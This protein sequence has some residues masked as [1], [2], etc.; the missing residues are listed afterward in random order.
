MSLTQ[1]YFV[2]STARSKLGR[3][4]NRSDHNLRR[5]VGH[6]NLL[7]T[8]MVELA[9]AEKEQEAWFNQSV[10]KASKPEEP[11]HIQWI[12]TIEEVDEDSDS[13]DDDDESNADSDSDI[14]DAEAD[15]YTVPARR[16]RSPPVTFSSIELSED[17]D[18]YSDDEDEVVYDEDYEDGLALTRVAS[19]HSPP[20]LLHDS[21]SDSEDESMP[22]S[23]EDTS[24]DISDKQ[25]HSLITSSFY[26]H[27]SQKALEDHYMPQQ[28]QQPQPQP[29]PAMVI[30]AC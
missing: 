20:E 8:L 28:Q 29:Q 7:D 21:E 10:S 2:A 6:A 4:A 23:P 14:Y 11:R 22:L 30:T 19:K 17:E 27:Q 5:L 26:D 13:D 1:T 9:D 16:V 18:M 12:D 24:M 3:E 25:C 15:Q